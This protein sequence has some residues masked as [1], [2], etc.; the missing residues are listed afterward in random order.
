MEISAFSL[1]KSLRLIGIGRKLY[2]MTLKSWK[3]TKK[4]LS[5]TDILRRL[6]AEKI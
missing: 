5:K 2:P 1:D 4:E 6:S 3:D